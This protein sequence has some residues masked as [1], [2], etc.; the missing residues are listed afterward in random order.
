MYYEKVLENATKKA[1]TKGIKVD[2][3]YFGDVYLV[4]DPV[5]WAEDNLYQTIKAGCDAPIF[6]KS[7]ICRMVGELQA[8]EVSNIMTF[9]DYANMVKTNAIP[10]KRLYL[11]RHYNKNDNFNNIYYSKAKNEIMGGT[12]DQNCTYLHDENYG[13]TWPYPLDEMYKRK[14]EWGDIYSYSGF[15]G[16]S[17]PVWKIALRDC[18]GIKI[19]SAEMAAALRKLPMPI[20]LDE[21]IKVMDQVILPKM[22][23]DKLKPVKEVPYFVGTAP[24]IDFNGDKDWFSLRVEFYSKENPFPFSGRG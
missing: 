10:G 18:T 23:E 24:R 13:L 3:P 14:S 11:A 15:M 20:D 4:A 21:A 2:H 9:S 5:K 16:L 8:Y 19:V 7:R 22:V 6:F 17:G 1:L 12:W